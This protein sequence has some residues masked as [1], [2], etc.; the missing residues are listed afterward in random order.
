M[1]MFESIMVIAVA[2]AQ[3]SQKPAIGLGRRSRHASPLARVAH[4]GGL[5]AVTYVLVLKTAILMEKLVFMII[6]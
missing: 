4:L 1:M 6:I 5:V 2:L 3:E